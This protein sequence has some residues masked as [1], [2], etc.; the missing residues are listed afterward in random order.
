MSLLMQVG[1]DGFFSVDG[2]HYLP[3]TFIDDVNVPIVAPYWTDSDVTIG[4]GSINYEVHTKETSPTILASVDSIITEYMGT[5]F[6]G[7]WM[8]LAKWDNV[9]EYDGIV[10]IVSSCMYICLMRCSVMIGVSIYE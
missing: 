10:N 4:V 2:G 8:L 9:P 7:E 5:E 6:H 1:T 3:P